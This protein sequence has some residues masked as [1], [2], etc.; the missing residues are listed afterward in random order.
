MPLRA[1]DEEDVVLSAMNSFFIGARE[2]HLKPQNSNELWKLLAT[3]TVRKANAKLRMYHADK[4][5]GGNVRGESVFINL[6]RPDELG[7]GLA[8]VVDE[9]Q[10][11]ELSDRLIQ[12]CEER[13]GELNDDVLRK[14]AMMR[15]QGY[16]QEEIAH[17]LNCS[18]TTVK[19]KLAKIRDIWG[20]E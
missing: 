9:E 14:I 19:R 11:P 6:Q 3:I 2:G 18:R 5:G 1:V 13:L 10:L 12:M 20:D 16:R 8:Q 17:E 7:N 15:L 4:R